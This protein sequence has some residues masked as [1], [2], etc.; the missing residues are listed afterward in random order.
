[1]FYT[2]EQ[3]QMSLTEIIISVKRTMR[4]NTHDYLVKILRS[5]SDSK[6]VIDFSLMLNR[7]CF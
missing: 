2:T 7:H 4:L 5:E 6:V 1:M 3:P